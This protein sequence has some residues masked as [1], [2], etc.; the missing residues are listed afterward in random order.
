MLLLLIFA[1]LAGIVTVFSP[2]ILPIL[3]AILSAGTARG[4]LRP[5]GVIVGLVVSFTFFTLTLSALVEAFGISAS[6]LRI[7]AMLL[8]AAFGLIMI[9]PRL[10]DW[11]AAKTAS[12]SAFGTKIQSEGEQHVK[13]G[14]W[15]GFIL[16]IALGLIWTPC[17]GPILAAISTLVATNQISWNTILLTLAYSIGAGIPMFLIAYGG[18]RALE[19]SRFLAKHSEGIRKGFGVLMIL[20][21]LAIAT[22]ADVAFQ[23]WVAR[24]FPAIPIENNSF[25]RQELNT[26]RSQDHTSEVGKPDFVGIN[27]WLNSPPLTLEQLHGKVVLVDFWTYSCINC[28][29]TLPYITHWYDTYKDKGLVVVGVHTPEFA[30]EKDKANVADAIKRFHIHYPVALDNHYKTWQAFHNE[31]WPA[32]YLFDQKGNL[33][34]VHY[35]EGGYGETENAIRSLLGLPPIAEKEKPFSHRYITPETYLGYQRAERTANSLKPDKMA[36]YTYQSALGDDQVGLKGEWLVGDESITSD[37]LFSELDLNFIATRVYLVLGGHSSQPITVEL[38]GKHL[39]KEY[40]TVDMD[41]QGRIFVKEPRKYDI[42]NL[43]GHYGRHLLTLH[44]PAGIQAYAFT[45]GDEN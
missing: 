26:L 11:F 7:A 3:P 42:L 29:R 35:G 41:S 45:F 1:F 43:H 44:F 40:Y 31:Y 21:A 23:Q 15:S 12:F 6:W 39:P 14:F 38:D 17:A 13:T 4:R 2:C 10:S 32:H 27:T 28:I 36:D 33:S 24:A 9:F 30:F 19:S 22:N 8:I 25:V 5:L 18:N 20:T 34:M 16:G 37:G